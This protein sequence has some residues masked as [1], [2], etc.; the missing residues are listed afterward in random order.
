MAY[1]GHR[2]VDLVRRAVPPVACDVTT[3]A[4]LVDLDQAEEI[5]GGRRHRNPAALRPLGTE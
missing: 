3:R 5:L 1:L 2:H 4:V